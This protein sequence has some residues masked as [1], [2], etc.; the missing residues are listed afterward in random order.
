MFPVQHAAKSNIKF[1]E[2]NS[3]CKETLET[4]FLNIFF[5]TML[6]NVHFVS[7]I[8]V[9]FNLAGMTPGTA[10]FL[11]WSQTI[12]HCGPDSNHFSQQ[13]NGLSRGFL[14]V[15]RFYPNLNK[16]QWPQNGSSD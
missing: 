15:C 5:F 4:L 3:D 16:H 10:V 9:L 11:S 7:N 13:L 12:H 8:V 1:T 14:F 2:Y 6:S